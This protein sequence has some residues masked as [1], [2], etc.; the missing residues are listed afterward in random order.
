MNTPKS[1]DTHKGASAKAFLC[2]LQT[3]TAIS[4]PEAKEVSTMVQQTMLI[5]PTSLISHRFTVIA[6]KRL[7]IAI[8]PASTCLAQQGPINAERVLEVILWE[9]RTGRSHQFIRKL[10]ESDCCRS[11][12]RVDIWVWWLTTVPTFCSYDGVKWSTILVMER[13]DSSDAFRA[14]VTF[15]TRLDSHSA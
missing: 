11:W 12:T 1:G 13:L 14:A 9:P 10:E 8:S 6:S 7:T 4:L 3:G 2:C 15:S 5:H